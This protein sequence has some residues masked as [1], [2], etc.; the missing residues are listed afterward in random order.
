[1]GKQSDIFLQG[2]GKAWLD[3][4]LEKLPAKDDPVIP[5]IKRIG[6]K[7]KQVLEVGCANGW[8]LM[9]MRKEFNCRIRGID[10]SITRSHFVAGGFLGAGAAHSI[11]YPSHDFDVVIYGFC[12][13]L[14]DPEDYLRI[15]AEGDRVLADGGYLIIYD[16]LPDLPHSRKYKH[17]DGVLTRKMNFSRLWLGHPAYTHVLTH[18][19]CEDGVA[20]IV[21]KKDSSNAFP[22]AEE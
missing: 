10:P 9:E 3:R 1:M 5:C 20:V 4:N 18:P 6:I 14:C 2:E 8:R 12:L 17:H 16:F 22:L 15:A 13:Y 19:S 21:L 7:P 11:P